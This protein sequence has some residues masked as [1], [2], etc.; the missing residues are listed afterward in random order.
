MALETVGT[1]AYLGAANLI[2]NKDTMTDAAVSALTCYWI[3]LI[4]TWA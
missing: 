3:W 4:L 1:S 2:Q